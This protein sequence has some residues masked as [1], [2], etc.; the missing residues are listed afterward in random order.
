[1]TRAKTMAPPPAAPDL[2]TLLDT[3]DPAEQIARVQA[4]VAFGQAPPFAILIS[5][6][7]ANGAEPGRIDLTPTLP[8]DFETIEAL[9]M[10]GLSE[11]RRRERASWQ[12]PPPPA[13]EG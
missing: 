10:A 7:P 13:P 11:L 5:H 3:T 12:A 6:V 1:M 4:L 9:L 2:S 8:V